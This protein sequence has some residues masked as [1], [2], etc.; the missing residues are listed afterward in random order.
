MLSPPAHKQ[1]R[2][3]LLTSALVSFLLFL[4]KVGETGL[5]EG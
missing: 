5:A 1:S 4:L 2:G 3:V